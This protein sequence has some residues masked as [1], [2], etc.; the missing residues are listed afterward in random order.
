M[1]STFK[2]N[3]GRKTSRTGTAL[4]ATEEGPEHSQTKNHKCGRV[5]TH[6]LD[7]AGSVR[8]DDNEAGSWMWKSAYSH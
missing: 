3:T 2:R 5:M 7:E 6:F 4:C 1:K 8:M